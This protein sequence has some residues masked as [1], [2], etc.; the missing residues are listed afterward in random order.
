VSSPP[1]PAAAGVRSGRER[2]LIA[3]AVISAWSI[4]PP[5]LGPLIGLEL[6]VSSTVEVVDHVLPGLCSVV[7]ALV[8]LAHARRGD[9]DSMLALAALGICVLAGLFQTVSHVTL[10]LDAGAPQ[11]PVDAVVLH[12]TPGPVLL[13]LAL[14]LLL[15]SDPQDAAA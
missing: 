14:W 6:D 15:R 2:W 5:Y 13:G 10:V 8:A 9:T 12:A 4:V 3:L 7:A 11:Q 1:P